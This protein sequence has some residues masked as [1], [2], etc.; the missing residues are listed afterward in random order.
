[1]TSLFQLTLKSGKRETVGGGGRERAVP[2][3]EEGKIKVVRKPK[4]FNRDFLLREFDRV[5]T[6]N[7]GIGTYCR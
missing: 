4:Y 2:A 5:R 1:M 7:G 3:K 6:F